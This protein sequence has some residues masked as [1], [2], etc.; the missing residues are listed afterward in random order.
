[1]RPVKRLRTGLVWWDKAL[2]G[3]VAAGQ[4]VLLG[5]KQGGG[6]TRLCLQLAYAAAVKGWPV[7]FVSGEMDLRELQQTAGEINC[8]HKN[9]LLTAMVDVDGLQT[10]LTRLKPRPVLVIVDS[11]NMLTDSSVRG[12]NGSPG[13]LRAGLRIGKWCQQHGI[14]SVFLAH[15]NAKDAVAGPRFLQ[16]EVDVVALLTVEKDSSRKLRISKNRQGPE[17][18]TRLRMTAK[19]L[20][21]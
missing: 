12:G 19:G 10:L 1:M 13:Q 7:L 4:R 11:L 9:I 20:T 2:N 3:G 8:A 15:L 14:P 17:T 21:P 6:K 5:G 18:E 16:H